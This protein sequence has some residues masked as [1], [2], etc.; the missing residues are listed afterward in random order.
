MLR[1]PSPRP[2]PPGEG[3]DNVAVLGNFLIFIAV[4]DFVSSAWE[5]AITRHIALLNI[6]A[7]DSP[8]PGGEGR[9]EGGCKCQALSFIHS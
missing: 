2:S 8:S 5:F 9:G 6:S 7:N 4:T 1:S 3:E